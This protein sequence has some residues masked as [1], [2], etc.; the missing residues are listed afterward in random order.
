MKLL[1]LNP[2]NGGVVAVSVLTVDTNL[3]LDVKG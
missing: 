2:A 1:N 3:P